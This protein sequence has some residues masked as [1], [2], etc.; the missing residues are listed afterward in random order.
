MGL[1]LGND[2]EPVSR[3]LFPALD[4]AIERL[5]ALVPTVTM[6]GTGASMFAVFASR[7]EGEAALAAV[8]PLGYPARMCRAIA[9][10]SPTLPTRGRES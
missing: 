7:R 10:P 2:L 8:E 9:T 4:A 5:R 1:T 3:R 6:S